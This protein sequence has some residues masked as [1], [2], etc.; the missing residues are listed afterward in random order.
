MC[1]LFFL[2]LFP[3]GTVPEGTHLEASALVARE[4]LKENPYEKLQLEAEAVYVYDVK[5]EK[6]LFE[7]NA[8]EIRPLASITKVMTALTALS[9]VPET[10]DIT[11]SSEALGA[12]GDSG[13]K[14]TTASCCARTCSAPCA[15]DATRRS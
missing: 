8:N 1:G 14:W 13:L 6:V 15:T 12:E 4:E 3:T 2:F 10:T 5:G 9:L 7:K 11:I